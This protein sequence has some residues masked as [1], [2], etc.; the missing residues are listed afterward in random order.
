MRNRG[1][2]LVEFRLTT[3]SYEPLNFRLS[4]HLGSRYVERR[5]RGIENGPNDMFSLIR[6]KTTLSCKRVLREGHDALG[7]PSPTSLLDI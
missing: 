7:G 1:V 2:F 3:A 5:I 4:M 6:P